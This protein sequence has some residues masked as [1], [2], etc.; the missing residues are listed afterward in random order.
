[1]SLLPENSTMTTG[2][3]NIPPEAGD[4]RTIFPYPISQTQLS[5]YNSTQLS[6]GACSSEPIFINDD[7]ADNNRIREEGN[8]SPESRGGTSFWNSPNSM[9][10][11]PLGQRGHIHPNGKVG[12]QWSSFGFGENPRSHHHQLAE[13]SG[14]YSLGSSTETVMPL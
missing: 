7:E 4:R 13:T 1:M 8:H 12:L 5:R 9:A 14:N 6:S 3:S 2:I 11:G 10:E